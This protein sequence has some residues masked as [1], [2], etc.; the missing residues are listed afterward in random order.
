MSSREAAVP[1]ENS[2]MSMSPA[3]S[4]SGVASSTSVP[5]ASGDPADRAEAKARTFSKPRSRRIR[6]V[7][8]PTA[9]VA[10]ITATLASRID[11]LLG[12]DPELVVHRLHRPLDLG[13][14]YHTRDA[15]RRRRDDLDVDSGPRQSFEHVGGDAGMALHS[16]TDER[17]LGDLVV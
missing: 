4:A 8:V 16:G 17:H 10:P 7:T 12:Q 15:D 13:C 11:A 6:T 5:S 2:A 3:A 9:P 1:T 14:A